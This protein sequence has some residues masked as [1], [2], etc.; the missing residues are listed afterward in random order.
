MK[1]NVL[2]FL[3]SVL[4]AVIVAVSTVYATFATK[5]EVQ[6]MVNTKHEN[7][8]FTLREILVKIET[9]DDRLWELQKDKK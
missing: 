8:M 3:L 1:T 6:S 2:Q 5:T 9:I 4:V 7:V